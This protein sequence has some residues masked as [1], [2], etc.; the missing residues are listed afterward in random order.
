MNFKQYLVDGFYDEMYEADGTPRPTSQPLIDL[1]NSL[2]GQDLRRRQKSAELA[3]LNLGITFGVYGNKMGTEKIFPFDIIP[4][5]IQSNEWTILEKGLE[6]RVK[7]LNAFCADVYSDQKIIKDGVIPEELILTS[8][9]FRKQCMGV[10]PPQDIWTHISGIDLIRDDQGIFHVLEDN[11]C[12]PS[13]ISYVLENRAT[14]KR[15]YPHL[16]KT[17]N[18]RLVSN[19]CDHLYDTLKYVSPNESDTPNIAVLSPGSFNSAYFEHSYLAQQMGVPIVEGRDLVVVDGF[20]NVRTTAGL[21]RV[22]VLYRRIDDNFLDPEAFLKESML[23]VKGLF[24]CYKNGNIGIANAPGTGIADDKAIYAYTPEIIRYYLNEEPIIPIVKT[25]LCSNAKDREYVLKN[26]EKLVVKLVSG[27]GGYG[28]LIGPASTREQC[29][30]F[31]TLIKNNPRHYIAQPTISLSRAP[32]IAN[33]QIVGRHVDLRPYILHG[34]STY[35]LPGGL[36]RVA[37]IKNSLIVNS[38]QGGGSKDTWVLG[39]TDTEI[40]A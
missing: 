13:G 19:Y 24:E 15:T 4:R 30:K 10:K 16:F 12:C 11:V 25:Y 9:S 38:S 34:K 2:P 21:E 36:T 35:V 23:G 17:M 3:L 31:R 6:Q 5:V 33:N 20:I 14:L 37:L 28:M 18:V 32:T 29:N 22:D 26:I 7:A 8:S 40:N 39:D 1:I 27:A